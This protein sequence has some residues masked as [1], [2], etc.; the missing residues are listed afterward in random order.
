MHPASDV[1][2]VDGGAVT[3]LLQRLDPRRSLAAALGWTLVALFCVGAPLASLLVGSLA[4]DRVQLQTGAL[5]QQYALQVS[6]ALDGNLYDRLQWLR[7][8]ADAVASGTE[9]EQPARLR[10]LLERWKASLPELEWVAVANAEGTVIAA[11]GSATEGERI[12]ARAWFAEGRQR[13]WIGESPPPGGGTGRVIELAAPI[14]HRDGTLVGVIGARLSW[15]WVGRLEATLTEALRAGRPVESLL[16]DREG[17]VLIGPDALVGT[18]IEPSATRPPGAAGHVVRRWPDGG[19][20]LAGYAV[21]DGVG[22]FPGLGWTSW[23]REPTETAFAAARALARQI[24][25]G[26]VVIGL[27]GAVAGV[28]ATARLARRLAAITRSADE[29]RA[30]RATELEVPRGTDE[31]ARI[32]ASLRTLVDGLQRERASLAALNAE[33]DAR[34]AARTREVERMSEE[35]KYA[36]VVRERLRIAR[37]LHDTLAHSIM[38]LLAEIRLMR[39]LARTDPAAL[40]EELGRAEAAALQGLHEARQAITT[41]RHAAVRDIGLGASL[42]QLFARFADRKGLAVAFR[43][44]AGVDALAD[45]RAEA[46]YRIVEE[47]LHNVDRHAQ[48]SRVTAFARVVDAAGGE[49]VLEVSI[50]DDGIGF[51]VAA[52]RPGHF[53]LAGM[54][55]R[56][57]LAGARLAIDSV[58]GEGTRVT[59]NMPL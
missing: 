23:V 12:G 44:D 42:A 37:D 38:A 29:I 6:N 13:G 4:T 10:A 27:A 32:G 24:L 5:Y 46:L 39:R 43:H 31:A 50:E 33:L 11:T 2:D 48:A 40:P 36:A 22:D 26:L 30:G 56:A 59:V 21:S 34:V 58:P 18:V 16:A 20:Y 53:G 1:Q 35:N 51:D 45:S 28:V 57:E 15:R 9:R 19:E 3:P 8:M 47:A 52:P 7:A 41:L 14:R 55:E 25:A 54:R 49:R 17:R